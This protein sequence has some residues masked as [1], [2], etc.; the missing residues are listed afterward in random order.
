MRRDA[1]D[2]LKGSR[3][4]AKNAKKVILCALCVRSLRAS[5]SLTSPELERLCVLRALEP[6]W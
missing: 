3:K 5:M 6:L 1:V 2:N 4:D